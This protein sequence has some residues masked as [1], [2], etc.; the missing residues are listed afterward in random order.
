MARRLQYTVVGLPHYT[1]W[2]LYEPSVDDIKHMEE[3][4]KEK[5]AKAA[6]EKA[7][8]DKIAKINTQFDNPSSD[9][10]KDKA[11]LAS[12]AEKAAELARMKLAEFKDKAPQKPAEP[13]IALTLN[14]PVE[15][16]VKA[17]PAKP[18]IEKAKA[19][20]KAQ[21]KAKEA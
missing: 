12:M 14:V 16:E 7:D 1:I 13:E 11:Q 20:A 19:E 15:T 4:D 6:K 8:R 18:A 10:E 5:K 3:M 9:W 2:H 17:E 21:E